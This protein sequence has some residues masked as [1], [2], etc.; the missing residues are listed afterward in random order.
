[1]YPKRGNQTR[2]WY[3][4]CG[5]N[6][7]TVTTIADNTELTIN[8]YERLASGENRCRKD[9]INFGLPHSQVARGRIA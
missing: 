4:H 1:M 7:Q 2:G 8:A 6:T 5:W 9:G 3:E